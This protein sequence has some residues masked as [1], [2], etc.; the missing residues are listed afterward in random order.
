MASKQTGKRTVTSSKQARS[1]I[2]IKGGQPTQLSNYQP[3]PLPRR[4]AKG[5]RRKS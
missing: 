1:P 4:T 2:I 5:S 3:R